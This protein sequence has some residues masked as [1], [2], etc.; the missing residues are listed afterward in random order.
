MPKPITPILAVDII[1]ELIDS[2]SEIVLIERINEPHGWALPGGFVDVG[3]TVEAAAV[4]EAMEETSLKIYD[5]ELLGVYSDPSR[6]IRGHTVSV[7]YIAKA[8]GI[9]IGRDDARIARGFTPKNLPALAFDHAEIISDY[10]VRKMR[11]PY[12]SN[13]T[14]MSHK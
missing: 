10:W 12:L 9:P 1:I 6:D 13:I 4:R 14:I 3:E 2:H 8:F 11:N 7:V 5:L